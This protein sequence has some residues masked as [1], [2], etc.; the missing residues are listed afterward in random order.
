VR[1]YGL[2]LTLLTR[3]RFEDGWVPVLK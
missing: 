2:V 3:A 1:N